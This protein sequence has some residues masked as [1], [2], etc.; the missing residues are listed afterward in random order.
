MQIWLQNCWNSFNMEQMQYNSL[1]LLDM[2]APL[3]E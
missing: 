1:A 3:Q 2:E